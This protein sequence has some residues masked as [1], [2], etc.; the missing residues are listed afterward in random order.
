MYFTQVRNLRQHVHRLSVFF[1]FERPTMEIG[2]IF[3]LILKIDI[4]SN[5]IFLLTTL[6]KKIMNIAL[7]SVVSLYSVIIKNIFIV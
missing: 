3:I 1:C 6:G 5:Y 4:R 7:T 2:Y